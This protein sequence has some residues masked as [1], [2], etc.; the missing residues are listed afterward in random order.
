MASASI[1]Q[2]S[3]RYDSDQFA[4]STSQQL[5]EER[6]IT[7]LGSLDRERIDHPGVIYL[8]DKQPTAYTRSAPPSKTN[9]RLPHKIIGSV[10]C[11]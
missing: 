5:A 2:N 7:A 11:I 8:D 3:D 4:R 6:P 10:S 1:A 9:P